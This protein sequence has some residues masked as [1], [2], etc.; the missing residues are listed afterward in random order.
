MDRNRFAMTAAAGAPR[1]L[2]HCPDKTVTAPSLVQRQVSWLAVQRRI[3][4]PGF[5]VASWMRDLPLTVAGAAPAWPLHEAAPDSLLTREAEHTGTVAEVIIDRHA[6]PGRPGCDA[7]FACGDNM[8][9][10]QRCSRPAPCL[11]PARRM[12]MIR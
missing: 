5:P 11:C 6:P 12:R 7:R 9:F 10:A 2:E 1:P 4:L 8:R 3:P